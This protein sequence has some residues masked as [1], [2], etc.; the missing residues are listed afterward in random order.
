MR[1]RYVFEDETGFATMVVLDNRDQMDVC[2]VPRVESGA[3]LERIKLLKE[4]PD[5][6]SK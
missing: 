1:H 5:G 6:G 4:E 3:K 2:K